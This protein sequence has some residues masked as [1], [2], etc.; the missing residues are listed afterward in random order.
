MTEPT[1]PYL[2]HHLEPVIMILWQPTLTSLLPHLVPTIAMQGIGPVSRAQYLQMIGRAGRAGQAV[3]GE[4]FIIGKGAPDAASGEWKPICELLVAPLPSLRSQLLPHNAFAT[5]NTRTSEANA[6]ACSAQLSA[7]QPSSAQLTAAQASSTQL[8]T[9]QAS[10]TQLTAAQASSAQLTTAQASSTQL[11]TA[12]PTS[13]LVQ[14]HMTAGQVGPQAAQQ[15]AAVSHMQPM[16]CTATCNQQAGAARQSG[17]TLQPGMQISI[18]DQAAKS[19]HH[20]TRMSCTLA[21][22]QQGV[23]ARQTGNQPQPAGLQA[24]TKPA[25]AA[26]HHAAQLQ[27]ASLQSGS[28]QPA[29]LQLGCNQP[30]SLQLGSNPPASL[31]LGSNQPAA[32]AK[33]ASGQPRSTSMLAGFSQ[34]S[35]AHVSIELPEQ[36]AAL[37]PLQRMLLDAV[38]NGSIQSLQ[39]INRLAGSTLLAHQAQSDRVKKAIKAALDALG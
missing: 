38:A 21:D 11:T 3:T 34:P 12:K 32:A 6:R 10:S 9:A 17:T 26:Q 37:L 4:A 19:G 18:H 30:A 15:A 7:A 29:S 39:D 16:S 33:Q 25:A 8:T 24:V 27:P 13:Q 28:N 31:Q 23:G 35:A 36:D 2:L 14:Q 5:S 20:Q 1:L 22:T